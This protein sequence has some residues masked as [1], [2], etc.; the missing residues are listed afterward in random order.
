MLGGKRWSKVG[1]D[2]RFGRAGQ[3]YVR[4]CEVGQG[5]SEIF[6]VSKYR[7]Q[8]LE[9]YMLTGYSI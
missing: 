6:N 2:V 9:A 3:S 5:W 4:D 1:L 7:K 8:D